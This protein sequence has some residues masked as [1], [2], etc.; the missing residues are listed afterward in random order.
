MMWK[1]CLIWNCC[2]R[3]NLITKNF[4]GIFIVNYT[5]KARS[6]QMKNVLMNK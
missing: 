3:M 4:W 6:V 2:M 5:N 1:I